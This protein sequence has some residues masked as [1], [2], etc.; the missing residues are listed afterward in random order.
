M[1]LQIS[2]LDHLI[3][4]YENEISTGPIPVAERQYLRN[5][6]RTGEKL[7]NH[8]GLLYIERGSVGCLIISLQR[9]S[10]WRSDGVL[11]S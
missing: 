3:Q 5:I 2:R 9:S 1:S 11:R 6:R 4:P 10:A 8:C 7:M